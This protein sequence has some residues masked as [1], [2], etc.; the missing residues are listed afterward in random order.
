MADRKGGYTRIV[1]L[2]T[3]KGD[4]AEM[5]VL[6]WTYVGGDAAP[7]AAAPATDVKEVK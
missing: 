2:G 5:C 1:K 4:G 7:A 3:R 6:Q